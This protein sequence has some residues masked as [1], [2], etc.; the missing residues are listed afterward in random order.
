VTIGR[1]GDVIVVG[2]GFTVVVDALGRVFQ[3]DAIDPA[4]DGAGPAA[5]GGAVAANVLRFPA[6]RSSP[7]G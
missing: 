7:N 4:S 5:G 1:D 3:P 2:D 6:G